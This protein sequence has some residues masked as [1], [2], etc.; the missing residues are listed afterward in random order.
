[1]TASSMPGRQDTCGAFPKLLGSLHCVQDKRWQV[2]ASAKMKT[3]SLNTHQAGPRAG[4]RLVFI[5]NLSLHSALGT[6]RSEGIQK[7][8][9]KVDFHM[10]KCLSES[11][12]T[13]LSVSYTNVTN[14]PVLM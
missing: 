14:T 11:H 13:E 10:L 1:M 5:V 12:L 4:R 6:D 3:N 2:K 7:P 9:R 8:H